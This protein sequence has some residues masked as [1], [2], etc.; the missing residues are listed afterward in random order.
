M[1]Q[2]ID[3]LKNIKENGKLKSNRTDTETIGIFGHMIKF[4][5]EKGLPI[6]T[7]KK[8]SFKS[9]AIE[10]LWFL[11]NHTTDENYKDLLCTN[12]KFLTDNKV[13][14]WD[15]WADEH[16]DLGKVYGYQWTKWEK[17][18]NGKIEYINQID[19]IVK[20]LRVNPNDRR[21]ICMAWNPAQLDE[22]NLPPCHYSFQVNS[23]Y[24]SISERKESYQVYCKN[25]EFKYD[26][27]Y[28]EI[29]MTKINFPTRKLNLMWNQ[30]SVD[31]FLGL[32]YNITSYALLLQMLAQ[33]SML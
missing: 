8:L 14:I 21:M 26:E 15:E 16:G 19:N 4:D 23:E 20:S 13:T 28:A 9:I 18:V 12:T 22:M 6:L 25:N 32:P 30:R 17:H 5:L 31:T 7:T 10:L 11:G 24:M 33:A 1:K 29:E 27:L 3:L 2:Y